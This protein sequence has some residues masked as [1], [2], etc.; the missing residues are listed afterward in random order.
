[1]EDVLVVGAGPVG[2]VAACELA[3]QGLRPRIVDPLEQPTDQSRAV[4]LHPRSQEMLAALGALD[5]IDAAARRIGAVEIRAGGRPLVHLPL[6]GLPTRH[7]WA[8]DVPQSDTE[9]ALAARAAELGVTVERGV[10][11]AG[12]T[13]D[14]DGVDVTLR[15]A[16]S[17]ERVRVGWVVAA[18]GAHSPTRKAVGTAL[19]GTF[20]GRHFVFADV[21]AD[22]DL[23]PDTVRLFASPE[24]IS[25]L[26]PLPG[27]RVRLMFLVAPP[28]EGVSP[29]LELVQALAD[30]RMEGRVAVHR[31]R[32]L[33]F[34]EVHHGQVP[35]YRH[36]RVLLAGDA[37]H[38]HSPAGGQGM[39]TGMQ[40]A[41]GLA[42]RLA[43]VARGRAGAALLD[44]YDAERR[45]VGAAVIRETTALTAAGTL[46]GAPA[47]V[48]NA[49]LS[50]AGRVPR[51]RSAAAARLAELTVAYPGSPVVGSAGRAVARAARPGRHAP[52]PAGLLDAD[53]SPV[54]IGDLLR[55][56]GHLLLVRTGDAGVLAA[57]RG[58]LG[59]LGTVVPVVRDA[60]DAV[61]G[62]LV[63]PHDV[64][65]RTYGTGDDGLVLVRPDGYVGFTSVPAD[66]AALAAHLG[67][68]LRVAA[69]RTT[70][71]GAAAR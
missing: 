6:G 33:T 49:V 64:V 27:E 13:Q 55:R 36:G 34:F 26:F 1:M 41:A 23:P 9:A 24:G 50:A 8:L 56:P 32:W 70:V 62:A 12:L 52:D 42:W 48:R 37:A 30:R 61:A 10:G 68:A 40:D 57:L 46:T 17:E 31:A 5:R 14:A 22:T 43:L 38:V 67:D 66:P 47:A 39:N 28:A 60:A 58:T 69:A 7:P 35:R 54:R 3:R 20:T 11:M 53:G 21:D 15:G 59:D 65:G 71:P 29:T 45:P 25:G 16:R 4:L 44:S 19:A 18:D 51:L 2:L 63:D